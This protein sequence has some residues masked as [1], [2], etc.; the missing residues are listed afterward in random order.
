MESISNNAL[1][2]PGEGA[3]PRVGVFTPTNL[4]TCFAA[5]QEAVNLALLDDN[6]AVA[7]KARRPEAFYRFLLHHLDKECGS[8]KNS[9][10]LLDS[11]HGFNVVTS[12]DYVN[13][14]GKPTISSTK[15]LI[16]DLSYDPFVNPKKKEK[17]RFGEVLQHSLCRETKLRAYRNASQSYETVIQRKIVTSLPDV[18]SL[19]CACAGRKAQEG[20]SV[21]R[22]S[23]S[24]SSLWLPELIEVE[25]EE[26][27]NVSVREQIDTHGQPKWAK[28]DA[29]T[30]IPSSISDLLT[31]D[32]G[33]KKQKLRYRLDATLS[34]IRDE[35]FSTN[36][37]GQA[38]GHHVLH[39]RVPADYRKRTLTKQ[40][41]YAEQLNK[42]IQK[43]GSKSCYKMTLTSKITP[44]CIKSRINRVK[45]CL[46]ANK[47]QDDWVLFNGFVVSPTS[48]EDARAFHVDFKEPCIVMYRATGEN[49]K[50]SSKNTD[51]QT[52]DGLTASNVM[53]SKSISTGKPS[54][55]AVKNNSGMFASSSICILMALESHSSLSLS[56]PDLPGE[57]DIV[58]LDAEFV[59]VQEEESL[60]GD[61]GN[62]IVVRETR[63]ALARV[64]VI[65]CRT[66]KIII[67]DYVVPKEPVVDYLTRFSGILCGDLDPKTSPHHLVT[68]RTAHLKLRFL[69]E[70]CVVRSFAFGCSCHMGS[71][72]C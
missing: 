33:S 70:R 57:G 56:A 17:F 47:N 40:R 14:K 49:S 5:M 26:D 18:L 3:L 11:L 31:K 55:H 65:D 21:W 50:S 51:Q 22:T 8:K 64:S 12:S 30:T 7:V 13:G 66:H 20:L 43:S 52:K 34:F 35:T 58:A 9:K 10:K 37:A 25:L 42:L 44:A 41:E 54:K 15:S 61:S 4:L 59:S 38:E 71:F 19:S 67:D 29:K 36:E 32:R 23:F 39:V 2:Y 46:K 28:F 72:C 53:Q 24:S 1:V 48:V 60:L 6:P 62:K 45:E 63:H 16:L 69:M 27:G 68:P